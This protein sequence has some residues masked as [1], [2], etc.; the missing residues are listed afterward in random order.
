PNLYPLHWEKGEGG[1]RPQ[2]V[3]VRGDARSAPLRNRAHPQTSR[4]VSTTSS[5]FLRCS[6]ALTALPYTVDEKPHCGLRQIWSIGTN[7]E[8]SSMRR[9][10]RSL[11]SSAPFLVV[12]RPRTTILPLG[13]KRRGSKPPERASSYS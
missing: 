13:T 7:F 10:S 9:L 5:S 8:A 3:T 4:A 6:S 1:T 11:L 12:T 2:R